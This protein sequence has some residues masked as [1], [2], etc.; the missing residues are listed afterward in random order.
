[1]RTLHEL[2]LIL[3]DEEN[4]EDHFYSGLCNY[5]FMLYLGNKICFREQ[6]LIIVNMKNKN[7]NKFGFFWKKGVWNYRKKFIEKHMINKK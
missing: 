3:L 5:I 7:P 2:G 1:M 6:E 4:V